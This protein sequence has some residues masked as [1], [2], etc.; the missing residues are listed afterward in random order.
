[1]RTP[2]EILRE[3]GRPDECEHCELEL[4][5]LAVREA[6]EEAC[7][8]ICGSCAERLAMKDTHHHVDNKWC[9]DIHCYAWGIRDHFKEYLR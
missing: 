9:N 5:R 1:M 2:E 3:V 7:G 8:V 4:I 6:V